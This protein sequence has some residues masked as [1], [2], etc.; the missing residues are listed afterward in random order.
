M[1]SDRAAS[2]TTAFARGL[3]VPLTTIAAGDSALELP[4]CPADLD[5]VAGPRVLLARITA[6]LAGVRDGQWEGRLTMEFRCRSAA[7]GRAGG[8]RTMG[9]EYLYQWSGRAWQLYQHSWWRAER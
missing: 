6:P 3:E 4:P 2:I 9:K 8:I 5:R 1:D 7:A